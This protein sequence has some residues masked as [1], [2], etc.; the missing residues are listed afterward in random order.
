VKK[1][2]VVIHKGIKKNLCGVDR[3]LK[4]GGGWESKM[5][6]KKKNRIKKA[7][8]PLPISEGSFETEIG[9]VV[10]LG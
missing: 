1:G 10:L 6:E 8:N 3:D 9:H 7:R 5:W 4:G 2:G